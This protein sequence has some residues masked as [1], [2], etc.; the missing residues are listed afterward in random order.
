MYSEQFSCVGQGNLA[1][2]LVLA[3]LQKEQNR[4]GAGLVD[5]IMDEF[6]PLCHQRFAGLS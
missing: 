5:D 1:E 3:L 4:K 2:T 6:S